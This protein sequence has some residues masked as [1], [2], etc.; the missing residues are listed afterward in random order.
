VSVERFL[1]ELGMD[2]IDIVLL[3]CQTK[4]DWPTAM[5]PHMDALAKL[6][7]QGK[8]RAHGVSIHSVPALKAV[9]AEPWVDSVNVRINPYGAYMDAPPNQVVP[10]LKKIHAAGKGVVGMKI[11]GQGRFRTDDVKKDKSVSFALKLDCVDAMVV[12]C[13]KPEEV[14]DL[15]ERVRKVKR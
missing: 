11:I 15:A 2:T 4:E 13:E 1:K 10:V 8:I 9:A 14:D 6:K 7:E 3:H 12:G 5:R